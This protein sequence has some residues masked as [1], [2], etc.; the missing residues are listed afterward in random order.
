MQSTYVRNELVKL[1]LAHKVLNVEQEVETLLVRDAGESIIRILTLQV[2][3]QLG[4]LVVVAK[5]LH[6]VLQ[7]LP[8]DDGGEVAVSL[9]VPV[10]VRIMHEN[11]AV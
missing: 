11:I 6:R 1:R 2:H 4:E 9:A 10:E 8:S 7:G 5:V 3:D